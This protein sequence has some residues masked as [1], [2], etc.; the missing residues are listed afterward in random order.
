MNIYQI[1]PDGFK[2]K[3]FFLDQD[4]CLGHV[5]ED[6]ALTFVQLMRFGLY[7]L[8]LGGWWKPLKARFTTQ[9]GLPDRPIPDLATWVEASVVLS[10]KAYDA[11]HEYLSDY[12]EFLEISVDGNP[13]YI[14]NNH[15]FGLP[16]EI[17]SKKEILDGENVGVE[18]LSFNSIDTENKL[19]FKTKFDSCSNLYCNEAFK[20]IVEDSGLTGIVFSED[21]TNPFA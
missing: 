8:K 4:L 14:F 13:Y 9:E 16:D 3:E 15:V 7:N 2:F 1:Q 10:A 17:N 12:G 20:K 11:L 6:T 21:F 19:T 18:K 5:P